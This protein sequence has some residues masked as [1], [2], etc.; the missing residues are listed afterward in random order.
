MKNVSR[1]HR[2][3]SQTKYNFMCVSGKYSTDSFFYLWDWKTYLEA[4][5][6]SRNRVSHREFRKALKKGGIL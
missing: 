4:E 6:A 1:K 3:H 5:H 2:L